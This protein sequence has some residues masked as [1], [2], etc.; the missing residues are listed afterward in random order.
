IFQTAKPIPN[1]DAEKQVR[2]PISTAAGGQ[3]GQPTPPAATK[4]A[5]PPPMFVFAP[6]ATTASLN[7]AR[8][9]PTRHVSKPSVPASQTNEDEFESV[10]EPQFQFAR[11]RG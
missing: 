4:P 11:P 3:H 7:E 1:R 5:G 6:P 10:H 9:T 8:P 2:V